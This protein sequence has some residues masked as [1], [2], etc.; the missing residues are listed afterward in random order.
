[1][2]SGGSIRGVSTVRLCAFMRRRQFPAGAVV[3]VCLIMTCW[4]GVSTASAEGWISASPPTQFIAKQFTEGLGRPPTPR[5]WARWI[6]FFSEPSHAC[7]AGSMAQLARAVFLGPEFAHIRYRRAEALSALLRALLNHDLDAT[8]YRRHRNDRRWSHVVQSIL[9]SS[10]FRGDATAI[11]QRRH[12][13]YYFDNSV[14]PMQ[15]STGPG[16]RGTAAQLQ[17]RLDATQRSGGGIVW[18]ARAAVIY[19]DE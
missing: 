5:E 8:T 18:L 1:M 13:A 9:T 6:H 2:T 4:Y 12:P 11:C 10:A 3:L 16:F 19:V 15:T 17:A 7:G 14:R